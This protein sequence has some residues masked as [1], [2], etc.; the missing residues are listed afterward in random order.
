MRNM[1][2]MRNRAADPVHFD[3]IRFKILKLK[4]LQSRINYYFT[5]FVFAT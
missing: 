2:N 1:A 5:K 4:L 3:R